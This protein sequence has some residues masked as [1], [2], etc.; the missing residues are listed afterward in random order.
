MHLDYKNCQTKFL[1]PVQSNKMNNGQDD[2]QVKIELPQLQ[3]N[4]SNIAHSQNEMHWCVWNV[5][6]N[7]K[8]SL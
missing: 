7:K 8:R 3:T 5:E 2:M 4:H 1:Q 6:I